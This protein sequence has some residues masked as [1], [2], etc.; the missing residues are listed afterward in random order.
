MVSHDAE[1]AGGLLVGAV[2]LAGQ[3]GDLG[4]DAGEGV[5][6]VDGLLAGQHADG[7]LQA[8]AGIDV[9]LLQ[10][11]EGA[12]LLLVVLHE[13]VV[14]DLQVTA[15]GAGRRAVGA[16]GG[17]IADDEHLGVGTAG[18]GLA[19]GAPP[20]VLLGQVED[21]I[22]FNAHGAPDVVG[23]LVTGAVLI[24]GEDGEGQ[25][26]LVQAQVIGAGQELPGPGDG[27]LLEVI[28]QGPVAQ[29]FE[30]GQVGRI[31]D[32]LDIAGT[33]A[34][35]HVGQAGA[36]GMG[37]AHQVGHEGM[38]TGGGEEDGGVILGDDGGRLNALMSLGLHEGLEHFAQLRR[39]DV[40]HN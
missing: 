31:A 27:F 30:E 1:G 9:L 7:T 5:G 8:H 32:F 16:A 19:G 33:D 21:V 14:P 38:H 17:L 23:F 24:A 40:L 28:A 15:A 3:L 12:V 29:H 25:L 34:L 6:L 18:A 39:G 37:S 22:L 2:L 4:D 26:V 11:D 36:G 13:H 10:R 20:V 35:L